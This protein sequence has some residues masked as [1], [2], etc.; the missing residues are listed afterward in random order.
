MNKRARHP[1]TQSFARLHVLVVDDSAVVR[2]VMAE[3]LSADGS[4]RVVTAPDPIVAEMKIRLDRPDVIVLDLEM[5]RMDGLTFLRKLMAEDPIPVVV[6]SG[7]AQCGTDTALKALEDGAVE[8]VAKPRIGVKEFL[9]ESAVLLSDAIRAAAAAR[10]TQLVRRRPPVGSAAVSRSYQAHKLLKDGVIAVAASTGGTE[11][12]IE[13]L[14][15]MESDTPGIVIVQHMPAKFTASFARR[16]NELC[17]VEVREA[18]DGEKVERG[19]ALIAP[20]DRHMELAGTR[21]HYSVQISDGPLV[22]RH[23]PSANVLFRSVA[24][25]AGPN[26][27]GVIMTGMGND[28]AEGMLEMRKSGAFTIAQD[29]ATSVVFGMPKEALDLGGVCAVA[30]LDRLAGLALTHFE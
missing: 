24:K 27:A 13:F 3:V 21:N 18:R 28:G 9:Q 22:S 26:A 2:Q 30:A 10:T 6:C 16:L 15:P 12:L 20:G 11:A 4:F 29:E 7:W 14:R 5:P 25:V 1:G 19:T 17:R 8:I 23:R